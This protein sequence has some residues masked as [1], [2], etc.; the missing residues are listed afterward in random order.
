MGS[1]FSMRRAQA[2]LGLSILP[3]WAQMNIAAGFSPLRHVY[4]SGEIS[5]ALRGWVVQQAAKSSLYILIFYVYG[6]SF[7]YWDICIIF[8]FFQFCVSRVLEMS[9]HPFARGEISCCVLTQLILTFSEGAGQK[10]SRV[11][12]ESLEFAFTHSASPQNVQIIRSS[13]HVWKQ[14]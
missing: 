8:V 14:L 2:N 13:V 12:L 10:N 6:T 5:G 1:T 3:K 11:S 7:T 4:N 9:T